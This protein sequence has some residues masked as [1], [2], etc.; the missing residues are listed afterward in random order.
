KESHIFI[1]VG[2]GE[3]ARCFLPHRSFP[4]GSSASLASFSNPFPNEDRHPVASR[5]GFVVVASGFAEHV[6]NRRGSAPLNEDA[7]NPLSDAKPDA[8]FDTHCSWNRYELGVKAI[9]LPRFKRRL[10]RPASN[11]EYHRFRSLAPP[12]NEFDPSFMPH[13]EDPL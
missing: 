4:E 9:P 13:G 2:K 3:G 7:S 1:W 11:G 10:P 5:H 8:V 6:D 12:A